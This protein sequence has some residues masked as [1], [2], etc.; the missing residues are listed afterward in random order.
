[1]AIQI[2]VVPESS[3]ILNEIKGIAQVQGVLA[4]DELQ[5]RLYCR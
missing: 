3:D 2:Y 1:M 5:S 4:Y